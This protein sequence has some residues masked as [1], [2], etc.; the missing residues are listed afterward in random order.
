[1]YASL[2]DMWLYSIVHC[3][4]VILFMQNDTSYMAVGLQYNIGCSVA[5]THMSLFLLSGCYCIEYNRQSEGNDVIYLS[6][7]C[8]K[9][10]F[11]LA[12]KEGGCLFLYLVYFP[13]PTSFHMV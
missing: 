4:T 11:T 12:R 2:G 9:M 7:D 8:H 10:R 1:M 13:E 5:V 3:T 6:Y